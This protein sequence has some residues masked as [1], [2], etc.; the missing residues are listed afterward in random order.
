MIYSYIRVLL[1]DDK[2]Q[3]S[4]WEKSYAAPYHD[5]PTTCNTFEKLSQFLPHV[6]LVMT[7]TICIIN[8]E[9]F[10]NSEHH[11]WAFITAPQP[12]SSNSFESLVA[13]SIQHTRSFFERTL[14]YNYVPDNNWCTIIGFTYSFSTVLIACEIVTNDSRNLRLWVFCILSTYCFWF[15]LYARGNNLI[16]CW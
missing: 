14:A 15:L 4:G 10:F 9:L 16:K 3:K 1:A 2:Y 5:S 7:K 13:V 6:V 12:I 8:V 11:F